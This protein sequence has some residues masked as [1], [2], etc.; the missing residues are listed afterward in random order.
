MVA[1]SE[2]ARPFAAPPGLPEAI[3]KPL[4]QAFA[5]AFSDPA[6]M[7]LAKKDK[8]PLNYYGPAQVQKMVA[9]ALNQPPAVVNFLKTLVI[10]E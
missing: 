9:D 1:M 7:N 10:A 2:I 6:I 3:R 8:L 4:Q 5:D